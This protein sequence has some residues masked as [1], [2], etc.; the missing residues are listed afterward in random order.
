MGCFRFAQN[1][2]FN[3][4]LP[5]AASRQVFI[6]GYHHQRCALLPVQRHQEIRHCL[7]GAVIQ[8]TRRLVSEQDQRL[9]RKCPRDGNPL[10]LT[11]GELSGCVGQPF[12]KPNPFQ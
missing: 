12:A 8:V 11:T 2:G 5:I 9:R 7:T 4:E 3:M 6:V 10:L 1:A